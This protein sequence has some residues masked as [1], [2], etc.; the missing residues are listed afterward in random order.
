MTVKCVYCGREVEVDANAVLNWE[1]CQM[2]RC[3]S[4]G[5]FCCDS[6]ERRLYQYDRRCCAAMMDSAVDACIEFQEEMVNEE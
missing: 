2:S 4:C 6:C 5:K 1:P 3:R